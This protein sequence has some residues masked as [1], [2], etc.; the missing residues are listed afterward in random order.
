MKWKT[1][2]STPERG[3]VASTPDMKGEHIVNEVVPAALL[4]LREKEKDSK[5]YAHERDGSYEFQL[6]RSQHQS[7]GGAC[8]WSRKRSV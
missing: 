4:A 6:N 8:A 3:A 1:T 7:G 2:K 5:E